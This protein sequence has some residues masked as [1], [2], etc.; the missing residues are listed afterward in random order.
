MPTSAGSSEFA[1]RARGRRPAVATLTGRT[2]LITLQRSGA[3]RA[4]VKHEGMGPGGSF[5]D[6]VVRV[7]L[8]AVATREVVCVGAT[9][10]T[11]SLAQQTAARDVALEVILERGTDRR[12]VELVRR[13]DA[14]VTVV[15]DAATALDRARERGASGATRLW[16]DDARAHLSA[17]RVVADEVRAQLGASPA[18]W[19]C[20]DY[21][22]D[23][24][25]AAATL[26][27]RVSWIRDDREQ[28][29]RLIGTAAARRTQMGHREG[30]LVSPVG[31]EVTDRAVNLAL[32]GDGHVVGLVPEGGHRYLGWW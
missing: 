19:V 11:V 24:R 17:L 6:R 26:G 22:V 13:F 23:R 15:A 14:R 25:R 3:G 7:Q 1:H 32:G 31:A 28:E 2:P 10:W 5:F 21:G 12:V 20:V 27:G 9:A 16:R 30:L 8:D 29:R 4:H 18:Q